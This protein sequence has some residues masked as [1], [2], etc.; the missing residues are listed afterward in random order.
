M[1]ALHSSR[2]LLKTVRRYFGRTPFEPEIATIAPVIRASAVVGMVA[3]AV[4][5]VALFIEYQYGL[6]TPSGGIAAYQADL[7]WPGLGILAE[8][9]R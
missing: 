8:A 4:W 2:H 6:R 1:P 5:I 9:R 3:A 7:P